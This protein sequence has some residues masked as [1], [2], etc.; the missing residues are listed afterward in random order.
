MAVP[1]V[2]QTFHSYS[3]VVIV[4]L[5]FSVTAKGQQIDYPHSLAL[6]NVFEE[7]L[8]NSSE[9]L[10]KLH[11][12]YFNP[13]RFSSPENVC[14]NVSMSVCNITNPDYVVCDNNSPRA[15]TRPAFKFCSGSNPVPSP[16]C[17]VG[18]WYFWS[19]HKLQLKLP[20]DQN[21][22]PSQL[23]SML[24]SS[25]VTLMFHTFDPSFYKIMRTLSTSIG[26]SL[27]Y[28]SYYQGTIKAQNSTEVNIQIKEHLEYMPCVDDAVDALNM[29]L[30]WVSNTCSSSNKIKMF[31]VLQAKAYARAN[32]VPNDKYYDMDRSRVT[33]ISS[34][35]YQYFY[36]YYDDKCLN[37]PSDFTGAEPQILILCIFLISNLLL[38]SFTI[39]YFR[40]MFLWLQQQG[41]QTKTFYKA[42][43]TVLTCLNIILLVLD[44]AFIIQDN[45]HGITDL[46]FI[47]VIKTPIV[48][49][50]LILET[51]VVC[52]NTRGLNQNNGM[53][54]NK[55]RYRFAHAFGLC[56]II[57]FVHRLV[58]DAI[59]SIIFFIIAPA[60][61]LGV[62]TLLLFIIASAIA[63]VAIILYK[64]FKRNICSSLIC[65]ALNGTMICGLL[66]VITL[67]YIV[68]VDNGLKSA[69]I[70]GLIL[71]L[72]PPL[73]VFV[74]GFVAN[75]KYNNFNSTISSAS[76][77]LTDVKQLQ[78]GTNENAAIEIEE[79]DRS[80]Q[81]L[82]MRSRHTN[83]Q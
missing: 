68:F 11:K 76:V 74:I 21:D 34:S 37:E 60:Q 13:S 3:S 59:I 70:G 62:V 1:S 79:S 32:G 55:K 22:N 83:Q 46:G 29:V 66:I 33:T 53:I 51:P 45:I 25:A 41:K 36:P 44:M 67:L 56:Q 8:M 61:T 50:I 80:Q 35:Y 72:V 4:L 20:D 69:G 48:L 47:L 42:S 54:M 77:N 26:T 30:M 14:L 27:F 16:N 28:Y 64:G 57:W 9:S 10:W 24:T 38:L 82:L 52:S 7:A 19:S 71:S 78:L 40:K 12:V 17:T 65:V 6:K 5:L 15:N 63:F 58:T 43:A 31:F 49:L 18:S 2:K 75:Q 23:N 39:L 73:A 81:P